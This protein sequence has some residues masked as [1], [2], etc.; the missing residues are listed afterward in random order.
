[1]LHWRGWFCSSSFLPL[2]SLPFLGCHG[3]LFKRFSSH[4]HNKYNT[5]VSYSTCIISGVFLHVSMWFTKLV[6]VHFPAPMQCVS[7]LSLCLQAN[8]HKLGSTKSISTN[9]KALK[10]SLVRS[11]FAFFFNDH[12]YWCISSSQ[13]APAGTILPAA[14]AVFLTILGSGSS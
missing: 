2:A 14:C 9:S 13:D 6:V 12:S 4:I 8:I 5:Y 3:L 10:I 1:M 7:F 11:W